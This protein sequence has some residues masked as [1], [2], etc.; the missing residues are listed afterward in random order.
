[1]KQVT[2]KNFRLF[3]AQ[4]HFEILDL[5]RPNGKNNGSG[6]T[7]FVGENGCGKTS[8]LD[9]IAL[10]LLSYKADS[11]T[12]HD[13][14]DPK[15][16]AHIEVLANA[17]FSV[18]GTM[19]KGTFKAKGFSFEAG[20]RARDSKTYL[21][22]VVVSDQ[23]YIRA[24]GEDKP[25]DGSPDLRVGVNNPFKGTRFSENDILF[26]D[27]NRTFQTRSGTYNPTRFD[28]LMEDFSYQFIKAQKDKSEDLNARFD[29]VK[30]QV[31]N[32]F[33]EDT[34]AKFKEISGSKIALSFV[35]NW[36]PF[37]RC[38]FSEKHENQHQVS[39]DKLGSGYEMIFALL[40]SF[41]LSQQSGKQLIVLIDEPELHLHP[42]L[43][44]R[45]VQVL[46]EFAKSAQVI[47]TTHSPLLVK[48]L[49]QNEY[50][51]ASILVRED[52][53]VHVLPVEERLLPYISASEINYL[54]FGLAT[55]EHHNELYEEL[56]YLRADDKGIKDFDIDFFHGEKGEQKCY[57]W[58]G[59]PNEV[60]IHTFV[61]NQIHHQRDNGKASDDDLKAS[62]AT[63]RGYLKE[64]TKPN[65]TSNGETK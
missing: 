63:M 3:D 48:H 38:F 35:D 45:F 13:L 7:V 31:A 34:V 51:S 49:F 57:P 15:H 56:K 4:K 17:D 65:G 43:E 59:N 22:S 54:A 39:V 19:P 21:S 11:F 64:L 58:M 55:E 40:Y 52:G 12:F 53:T 30:K 33:L 27:R 44:E 28:R 46:L 50:I 14:H 10:P 20:V 1:M 29:D 6:L 9:A 36:K 18:D 42:S 16:K 26:L 25:K 24:D 8:L 61:R 47:L 37:D 23:K 62:I 60:S 41:Y 32:K 2:I 5:N